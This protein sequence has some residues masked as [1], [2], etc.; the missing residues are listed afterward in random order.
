M[1]IL[2]HLFWKGGGAKVKSHLGIQHCP[3]VVCLLLSGQFF[4]VKTRA[5]HRNERDTYPARNMHK[6]QPGP[7]VNVGVNM[8]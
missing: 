7:R 6:W 3:C 2:V 1:T 5:K 8:E 4:R